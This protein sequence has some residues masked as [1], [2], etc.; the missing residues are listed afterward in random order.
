MD[1][2]MM[3]FSLIAGSVLPKSCMLEW[4]W[5]YKEENNDFSL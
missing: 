4:G 2:Q 5:E 3:P 1:L